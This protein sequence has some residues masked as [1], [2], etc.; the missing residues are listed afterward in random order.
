MVKWHQNKTQSHSRIRC[1]RNISSVKR[2]IDTIYQT[3]WACVFRVQSRTTHIKRN[4]CVTQMSFRSFSTRHS[5]RASTLLLWMCSYFWMNHSLINLSSSPYC[6]CMFCATKQQWHFVQNEFHW[7][8]NTHTHAHIE[9]ECA[10]CKQDST[11]IKANS[12]TILWR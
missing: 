4:A 5:T 10:A 3:E 9:L 2:H 11:E 6:V 7:C 1:H 8:T 12:K